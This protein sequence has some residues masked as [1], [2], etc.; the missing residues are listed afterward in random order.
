MKTTYFTFLLLLSCGVLK[1]QQEF[2]LDPAGAPVT[3][4]S[5]TQVRGTPY[6][7]EEWARGTVKMADST[8]FNDLALK[9]NVF[10]GQLL[11]KNSKNG[12]LM[13]FLKPVSVFVLD[14]DGNRDLYRKGFPGVDNFSEET[15]YQ[16]ISDGKVK[17]LYK[18]SKILTES[19]FYSSATSE[20]S[21]TDISSYYILR[22]GKMKK[23]R[24]SKKEFIELFKDK[25]NTI[26]AYLQ[27]ENIDYKNKN[28]LANLVNY[29]NSL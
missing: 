18:R 13:E 6:L 19:K 10:R 23:I 28:N 1:A 26:K 21:F 7:Y 5:L 8:V 16:V 29:Y 4:Q 3:E 15:F 27:A 9:F 14:K 12:G 20:S 17:L 22:D 25:E 2:L 24:P 11:Y